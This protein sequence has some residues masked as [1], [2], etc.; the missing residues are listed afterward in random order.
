MDDADQTAGW[1]IA[2]KTDRQTDGQTDRQTDRQ[3]GR[4]A[5]RQADRNTDRQTD[6]QTDRQT[7]HL[8]DLI[9]KDT[10]C[11]VMIQMNEIMITN[12]E[13]KKVQEM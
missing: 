5:D 10:K 7:K 6:G 8:F 13:T 3:T 1:I 12:K 11:Y 4:Q 9:D 2:Y